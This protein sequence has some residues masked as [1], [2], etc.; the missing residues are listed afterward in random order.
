MTTKNDQ[1]KDIQ[2]FATFAVKLY[3][4]IPFNTIRFAIKGYPP[5]RKYNVPFAKSLVINFVRELTENLTRGSIKYF[6]NPAL[7][8]FT[9]LKLGFFNTRNFVHD[10]IQIDTGLLENGVTREKTVEF[11]ARWL[12]KPACFNAS[13]DPIILYV[14]GGGM[15]VELPTSDLRFLN[16]LHEDFPNTAVISLDYSLLAPFPKSVE[17]SAAIYKMIVT[18]WECPR[19]WI[20]GDSSGGNL[21]LNILQYA[22]MTGLRLP[23]KCISISPWL[24][25]TEDGDEKDQLDFL[26]WQ[27]I[28]VFKS[29]YAPTLVPKNKF[30]DLESAFDP[31]LWEKILRVTKVMIT[32][33]EWEI[34]RHQISSFHEKLARIDRD[35]VQLIIE[36]HGVH[37]DTML[38]E[39]FEAREKRHTLNSLVDFLKS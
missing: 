22:G 19:V 14:H 25:T 32:Y 35:N 29:I 26:T 11:K 24:N 7:S 23:E 8:L 27:L 9:R 20:L 4:T 3:T 13:K 21:C 33:G 28:S 5:H 1:L 31:D 39:T 38:F 6:S 10:F 36:P 15:C 34:L 17:E 16:L 37:I 18:K 12:I 2:Q 30:L